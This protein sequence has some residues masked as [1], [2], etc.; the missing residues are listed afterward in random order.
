[1]GSSSVVAEEPQVHH[2]WEISS[3]DQVPDIDCSAGIE[4]VSPYDHP[5]HVLRRSVIPPVYLQLNND[6]APEQ[7]DE[8]VELQAASLPAVG[9][10]Q[11][12]VPDIVQQA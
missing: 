10:D 4:Q 2:Y 3:A 1:M 6:I 5:D 8:P 11:Y 12:S 9:N 7:Q